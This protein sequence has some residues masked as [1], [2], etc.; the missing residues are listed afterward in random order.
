MPSDVP[1]DP[2]TGTL[3]EVFGVLPLFCVFRIL[4]T[5]SASE[6]QLWSAGPARSKP[7]KRSA[8]PA[9]APL[10]C[11]AFG[12]VAKPWARS[13]SFGQVAYGVPH[14]LNFLM[15]HEDLGAAL[16]AR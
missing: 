14:Q 4:Q 9:L 13:C 5:N 12:P 15:P 8:G 3:L 6:L 7:K 16:K 10:I 1:H 11:D 2:T